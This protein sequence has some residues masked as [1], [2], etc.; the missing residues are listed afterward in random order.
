MSFLCLTPAAWFLCSFRT[1]AKHDILL[2]FIPGLVPLLQ[3]NQEDF[4]KSSHIY[5]KILLEMLPYWNNCSKQAMCDYTIRL[6]LC[7]LLL[8]TGVC[9][10][11]KA[12]FHRVSGFTCIHWPH[13][14]SL[15]ICNE[16]KLKVVTSSLAMRMWSLT[17]EKMV[18]W[19]KRLLLPTA[20]PPHS[21]LAPSF[22]PLSIRSIILSNCCLSIW[23]QHQAHKKTS[24]GDGL[25]KWEQKQIL[26]NWLCF[27]H[28]NSQVIQ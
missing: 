11:I 17:P 24:G 10:V 12:L 4:T 26:G 15:P 22:F 27:L 14:H 21:S 23:S 3:I 2:Y 5:H 13:P 8:T 20:A 1:K 25:I 7:T 6:F 28:L 9:G 16:L 18:G 19:M